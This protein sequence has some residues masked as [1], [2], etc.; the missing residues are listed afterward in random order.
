MRRTSLAAAGFLLLFT[1]VAVRANVG[2]P[3]TGGRIA[4]EPT[5]LHDIAIERETLTIDLRPLADNGKVRVEAVYYLNNT[6]PERTHDLQFAAGSTTSDFRVTLDDQLL[7]SSPAS[8]D[9]LPPKWQIPSRTP[10]IPGRGGSGQLSYQP[11]PATP[12]DFRATIAPGKHTL[13]V[14]YL[15]EAGT[16]LYGDPTVY[17]QF[18]YILAPARE[19]GGFGGLDVTIHLPP[20]WY[21]ATSPELTRDVDTLTGRFSDVPAD[22]IALTVQ[23]AE[24][25]AYGPVKT[26]SFVLFLIAT[27]GGLFACWW[28]GRKSGRRGVTEWH[29]SIVRGLVWGGAV[30]GTGLL[31]IAAPD[32][33][34][35]GQASHYGYGQAFA[36][37]G[38]VLLSVAVVPVGFAVSLLTALIVRRGRS[39][40]RPNEYGPLAIS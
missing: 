32:W 18:A 33:A 31:A 23:A 30:L 11:G 6:G 2:K 13:K 16:H 28:F 36:V 26:G 5:G 20:G 15:G 34:L 12:T 27:I 7:P 10:P 17:R 1:A 37:I 21:A 4:G 35:R 3:N 39:A 29:W 19:W 40:L 24:G 8:K 25:A 9:A 38:V 14:E 22:S